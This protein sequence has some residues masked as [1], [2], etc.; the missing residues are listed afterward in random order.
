MTILDLFKKVFVRKTTNT[1]TEAAV[2]TVETEAK[3]ISNNTKKSPK[4]SEQSAIDIDAVLYQKYDTIIDEIAYKLEKLAILDIKYKVFGAD[5]HKYH[6]N[7]RLS[8]NAIAALEQKYNI[9]LP[10]DYIDFLTMLGDGGAGAD[11]GL[12]PLGK[13]LEY[14]KTKGDFLGVNVL[15]QQNGERI[16]QNDREMLLFHHEKAL[17]LA[18]E[19]QNL[20]NL[21]TIDLFRKAQDLALINSN[22]GESYWVLSEIDS[23]DDYP[24]D[25][26]SIYL[27]CD[28]I[29][30]YIPLFEQG[31]GHVAALVVRGESWGEM[32]EVGC[33]G[34]LSATNLSFSEYYLNWLN[35]SLLLMK[36]KK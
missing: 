13:A 31:C 24:F 34:Q 28:G 16:W 35:K 4:P 1:A 12:Y 8:R 10:I 15:L 3:I 22:E 5:S 9:K 30:G 2:N 17:N 29:D 11:Y 36:T 20:E 25:Y 18:F 33:D 26:N 21:P 6:L 27:E 14:G 7:S 32:I 23:L 19:P